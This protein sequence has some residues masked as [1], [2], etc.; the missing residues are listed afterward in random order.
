MTRRLV[1]LMAILWIAGFADAKDLHWK[2]LPRYLKNQQ[3]I[4]QDGKHGLF[5]LVRFY[6]RRRHCDCLWT[7][8]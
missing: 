4:V 6:Q 3:V 7:A 1:L 2:D 5:R 8:N